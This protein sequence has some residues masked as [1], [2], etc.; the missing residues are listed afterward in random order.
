[1]RERERE[2]E[3]E[4]KKEKK[5]ERERERERES[6]RNIAIRTANGQNNRTVIHNFVIQRKPEKLT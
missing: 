5:K 2:R 1:M 4:R 6:E 3:R